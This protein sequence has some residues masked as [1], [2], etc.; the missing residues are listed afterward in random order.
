MILAGGRRLI[1]PTDA[2]AQ[3]GVNL[4]KPFQCFTS[5]D[6]LC[7]LRHACCG[8]NGEITN[9]KSLKEAQAEKMGQMKEMFLAEMKM[10]L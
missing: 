9:L 5:S 6:A 3:S 4:N 2:F 10:K 8:R 1:K 7:N